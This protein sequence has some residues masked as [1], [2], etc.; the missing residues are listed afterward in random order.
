MRSERHLLLAVRA[1]RLD[2]RHEFLEESAL[3]DPARLLLLCHLSR[4]LFVAVATLRERE[5]GHLLLVNSRQ[6]SWC[7]RQRFILD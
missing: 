5:F 6:R 7:I 1:H 4:L 3:R 2:A